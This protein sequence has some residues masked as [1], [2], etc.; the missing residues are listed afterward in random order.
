MSSF[1][2]CIASLKQVDM[3]LRQKRHDRGVL[4]ILVASTVLTILLLWDT[5][6][7]ACML[8]VASMAGCLW[9]L[10]LQPLWWQFYV[11]GLGMTCLE[12]LCVARGVW[13]YA[14]QH[15]GGVPPW[16]PFAWANVCAFLRL[17]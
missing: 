2:G 1:L 11:L 5:H 6:A 12:M 4:S 15:W 14:G 10:D 7:L 8:L 13:A 9:A 16:L 17:L 3:D